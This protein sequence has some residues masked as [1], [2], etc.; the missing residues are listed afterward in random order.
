MSGQKYPVLQVNGESVQTY[1]GMQLE[2]ITDDGKSIT[3]TVTAYAPLAPGFDFRALERW[4]DSGREKTIFDIIPADEVLM[5]TRKVNTY[6]GVGYCGAKQELV[7]LVPAID[8]WASRDIVSPVKYRT[9][10]VSHPEGKARKIASVNVIGA[11]EQESE[12]IT[13]A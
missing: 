9:Y 2:F 8:K 3:V 6:N 10:G 5:G 4:S 11:P 13:P 12:A 7:P 1:E